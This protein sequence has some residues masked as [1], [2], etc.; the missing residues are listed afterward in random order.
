VIALHLDVDCAEGREVASDFGL[1]GL[2]R[3]VLEK[4]GT[5]NVRRIHMTHGFRNDLLGNK[6]TGGGRIH[7]LCI[8]VTDQVASRCGLMHG[9]C[10]A[11]SGNQFLTGSGHTSATI[12]LGNERLKVTL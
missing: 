11:E 3:L 9:C 12:G 1:E 4:T 2:V 8:H 10:V 5:E 7:L 6:D